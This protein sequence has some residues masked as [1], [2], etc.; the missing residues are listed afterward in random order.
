V[1][2]EGVNVSQNTS[3]ID[4]DVPYDK[5][6]ESRMVEPVKELELEVQ[7]FQLSAIGHAV[8]YHGGPPRLGKPQEISKKCISYLI[9]HDWQLKST[10]GTAPIL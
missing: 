10:I 8:R 9:L 4:E 2:L 6:K 5:E 3:P 1:K 7:K